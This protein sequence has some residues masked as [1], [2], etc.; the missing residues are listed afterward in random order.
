MLSPL[1]IAAFERGQT[2]KRYVRAA[3]AMH[4]LYDDVSLADAVEVQRGA[5][6]GWWRGSK[7]SPTTLRRLA[8]ATGLA[9]DELTA[10]TYY[11]G[12][13]PRLPVP[14]E[15]EAQERAEAAERSALAQAV[16]EG[17]AA[18]RA[19]RATTGSE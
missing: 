7:P 2:F 16:D 12:Q 19:P 18:P 5:V 17:S 4:D 9:I 8:E 10:F 14:V 1:E 3:A 11:E 15:D 6:A 13:P